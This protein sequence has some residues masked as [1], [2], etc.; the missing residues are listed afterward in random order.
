MTLNSYTERAKLLRDNP[1][2]KS[3]DAGVKCQC[4][5]GSLHYRRPMTTE[6]QLSEKLLADFAE[7]ERLRTLSNEDLVTEC[8]ERVQVELPYMAEIC[9]R[10]CPEYFEAMDRMDAEERA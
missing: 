6:D 10:L 4:K 3:I 5:C 7:G 9:R 1:E 2:T 8:I